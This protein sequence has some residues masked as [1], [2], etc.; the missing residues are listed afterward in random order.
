LGRLRFALTGSGPCTTYLREEL[1]PVRA[2]AGTERVHLSFELVDTLPR[3]TSYTIVPPLHV[4]DIGYRAAHHSLTYDVHR[5]PSGLRVLVCPD[6]PGWRGRIVPEWMHRLRELNHLAPDELRAKNFLYGV[7]DYITHIAQLPLGQS[8]IHASS[9]E[10]DG[11]GVVLIAWAGVGKTTAVLRLV[12]EHGF[13]FLSDD[14]A[15]V[16]DRGELWR[17]PKRLQIYG[18]NVT[19]EDSL[20][21]LLLGGR[22]FLDRAGWEWR[23][24][25]HGPSG[26]RRRVSAELLFGASA[27]KR[28]APLTRIYCLERGDC[29]DFEV[30]PL[31]TAEM[32]RRAA[33]MVLHEIQPFDLLSRAVHVSQRAPVIPTAASVASRTRTVLARAFRGVP[34]WLVRIPLSATAGELSRHL[35]QLLSKSAPARRGGTHSPG[36][37]VGAGRLAHAAEVRI[38]PGMEQGG[39]VRTISADIGRGSERV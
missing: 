10:R 9:I 33:E 36:A 4:T 11:E 3:L 21:R 18:H 13:N 37:Q 38:V 7:F 29:R 26:V 35:L 30:H 16:D 5:T 39:A 22:S 24:M 15:L 14:L 31:S 27:V 20:Q 1:L 2:E 12:A 17:T 34:A 25:R 6:Q 32:S 23:L 19:G 8:Y 28:S